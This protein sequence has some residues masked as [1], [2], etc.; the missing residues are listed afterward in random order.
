[1]P[2]LTTRASTPRNPRKLT[3]SSRAN[4]PRSRSSAVARATAPSVS[5]LNEQVS[6]GQQSVQAQRLIVAN[7]HKL[8]FTVV[9]D[10]Y[11]FQS[12][13]KAERWNPT[14]GQWHVV[15]AIPYGLMKT[16]PKL[17]YLPHGAGEQLAKFETDLA[18][19]QRQAFL[20]LF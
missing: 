20:V 17:I 11:D 4:T 3:V 18:E 13:A 15:M 10:A 9:S 1:M 2:P 19:L 14:E 7:G 8:R 16:A 5:I 12:S 6:R